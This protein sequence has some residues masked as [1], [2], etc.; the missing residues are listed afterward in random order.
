MGHCILGYFFKLFAVPALEQKAL[1]AAD[2]A[3]QLAMVV[4]AREREHL[5]WRSTPGAP[6]T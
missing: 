5:L 4:S 3:R 2:K 6:A 1:E